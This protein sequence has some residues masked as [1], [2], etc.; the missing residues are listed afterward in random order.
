MTRKLARK[1][2]CLLFMETVTASPNCPA[3]I[4]R[5]IPFPSLQM[6]TISIYCVR[7]IYLG[8]PTSLWSEGC[9]MGGAGPSHAY[10]PPYILS[11]GLYSA[12][13]MCAICTVGL[14]TLLG[15]VTEENRVVQI[16][17]VVLLLNV[18]SHKSILKFF[19]SL[20]LY[21]TNFEE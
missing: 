9:F 10:C 8:F 14:I 11:W 4:Y 19:S 7:Y 17:A 2:I 12:L 16:F 3:V 21:C 13:F 15:N 18:F 20:S 1:E 5:C 6:F